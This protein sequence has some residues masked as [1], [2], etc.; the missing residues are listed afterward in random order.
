MPEVRG[1]LRWQVWWQV[2]WRWQ[3][4]MAIWAAVSVAMKSWWQVWWQNVMAKMR[5]PYFGGKGGGNFAWQKLSRKDS[6]HILAAAEV[7]KIWWQLFGQKRLQTPSVTKRRWVYMAHVDRKGVRDFL[8]ANGVV[9]WW[10][11]CW[12]KCWQIFGQHQL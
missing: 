1:S 7:S 4:D 12:Q 11:K 6:N 5:Q 10:Q 9:S 8:A 2:Q 3:L